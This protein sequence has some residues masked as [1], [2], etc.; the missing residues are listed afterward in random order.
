MGKPPTRKSRTIPAEP[1]QLQCGGVSGVVSSGPDVK[2]QPSPSTPRLSPQVQA[3][4]IQSSPA[5]TNQLLA[6]QL[7][8]PPQP[9]NPQK[10][11]PAI[12]H[13]QHPLMSNA[14]AS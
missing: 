6:Q 9:L 2:Q 12:I 10:M 4:E 5:S 13:I 8:N 1:A 7:T 14:T 11:Q 3:H